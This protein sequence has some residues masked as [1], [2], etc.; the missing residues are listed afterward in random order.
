MSM[1]GRDAAQGRAENRRSLDYPRRG[2][3]PFRPFLGMTL[4]E[5]VRVSGADL[6]GPG[7]LARTGNRFPLLIKLLDC[8]DWLS[9]QVH[10][11]D[12]QAA[13]LEGEGHFG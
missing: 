12:E 4:A 9:L 7:S 8:A 11:N 10:P 2:P 6:L 5:A 3:N 1:F 13:R